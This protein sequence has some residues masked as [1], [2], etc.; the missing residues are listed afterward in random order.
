MRITRRR[1][2]NSAALALAALPLARGAP[3]PARPQRV[4]VVGAGL[5][6][7]VAAYELMRSG[8]T[9]TVLEAR[10]RPGGRIRTRANAFGDGLYVEEGALEIGEGFTLVN[11]Y[12][13]QFNLLTAPAEKAADQAVFYVGGHRYLLPRGREP[14]WPYALSPEERRLGMQ[15]VW[16]KYALPAQRALPEPFDA[17]SFSR[18]ARALDEHTLADYA[19]RQGATDAA[20]L[21]LERSAQGPDFEHVSALQDLLWKQFLARS[22][23]A[24]RVAGG[25]ERLPQAFADRL[26]ARLHYGAQLRSI[27]QDRSE[28]R[29]GIASGAGVEQLRVDRAVIAI[30][31][32]V[33]RHLEFGDAFAR[34]K[35][36]LITQLR[37]ESVT[38]IYLHSRS[39]FWRAAG[40]DG[41]ANTDLPIG[42]LRDFSAGQSGATGILGSTVSGAASQRLGQLPPA[43][44]L[45]LGLENVT[46]VFPEMKESYLGGDTLAWDQEPFALGGWA[47]YAPGEMSSLFGNVASADGRLHFAGEHTS[48]LYGLEGAAQSGARAAR[49]ISAS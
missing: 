2:L 8:H 45:Q 24:Q 29:L 5:A 19:R 42:A 40:L 3:A 33:L 43:E 46:R 15:G 14:D 16:D 9:V 36:A 17:R 39:R 35:R 27:A 37:Y 44:R 38:R 20:V 7:L 1:F 6:G 48:A 31:F 12:L 21:L 32:S 11:Q 47:Y 10:T 18:A 28:V 25:N 4:A 34:H 13:A 23:S 49:E 30:P 26:G 22:G 41:S